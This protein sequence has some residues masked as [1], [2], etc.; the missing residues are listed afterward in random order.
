MRG[1]LLKTPAVE[2][3]KCA[4]SRKSA[5]IFPHPCSPG[6]GKQAGGDLFQGWLNRT[7]VL[8]WSLVSIGARSPR[9]CHRALPSRWV[10]A[11]LTTVKYTVRHQHEVT[12]PGL[13]RPECSA[14]CD[15]RLCGGQ[16]SGSPSSAF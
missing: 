10:C 8:T 9:V 7:R 16:D 14:T 11:V 1:Y 2:T 4:D 12:E 3:P 5:S 13:G 6:E 15:D